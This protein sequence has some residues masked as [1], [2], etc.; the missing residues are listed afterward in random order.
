MRVSVITNMARTA[1]AILIAATLA[2]AAS[3]KNVAVVETEVDEESGAS[4]L[5]SAAEVRLVTAELRREAVKNLPQRKYSVM[6]TETVMAQGTAV[7]LE[8]AEENCVIS[9]GSKIGADFIVRGH[10]SRIDAKLTLAVDVYDTEDGNL[11]ASSEAVRAEKVADLLESAAT[12]CAEMYKN[13]VTAH[14]QPQE[15]A[16]KKTGNISVVGGALF[17]T[18]FGGGAV[19]DGGQ[20]GMPLYCGGAFVALD[21]KYAAISMAYSKGGGKWKGPKDIKPDNLPYMRRSSLNVGLSSKYPKFGLWE[22]IKTYPVLD[23]EYEIPVSGE[24]EYEDKENYLFDG[25]SKDKYTASALGALWV[26]IGG[27]MDFHITRSA[28]LRAELLY[29]ARTAST[30]EKDG[31]DMDGAEKTRLGHGLNVRLGAGMRL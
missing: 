16:T 4:E 2:S 26:R 8:C 28:Y 7:L 25:N 23:V 1:A 11:I 24:L 29:G 19:W 9:L 31:K 13:F 17:T 15:S 5:I 12:A 10:I 14:S 6:T 22:R 27:G 30:F 20:I 18:D 3:V 21:I